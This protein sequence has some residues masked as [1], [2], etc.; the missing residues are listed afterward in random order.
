MGVEF[1]TMDAAPDQVLARWVEQIRTGPLT[2]SN[3]P[4]F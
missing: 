4:S 3:S 1:M 2:I